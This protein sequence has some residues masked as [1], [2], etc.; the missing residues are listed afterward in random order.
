M[1][2]PKF[3]Y[4]D[5][6]LLRKNIQFLRKRKRMSIINFAK[7]IEMHQAYLECIEYGYLDALIQ[8]DLEK[9]SKIFGI[10][11]E[12]IVTIDLEQKYAGK[13]FHYSR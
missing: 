12:E 8:E 3:V 9:I 2:R 1:P 10:P 11:R 6:K 7:Y 13:R 4:G 5:S